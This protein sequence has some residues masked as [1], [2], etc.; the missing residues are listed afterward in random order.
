M[1]G[2]LAVALALAAG[3]ARAEPAPEPPRPA[4]APEATPWCAPELEALAD[5]LCSYAPEGESATRTLVVFL[6]GVIKPDTT[7]QYAQER[8]IVRGAKRHGFSVIMPRGRRGIGPKG[9]QDFFT[10]PTSVKAQRAVEA[11]LL[12]EWWSARAAL[13]ARSGRPF[14]RVYLVGFSNG[15]YYAA[16]LALR[17]KLAVDGYAL[18]AGGAGARYLVGP[19]KHT[20]RRPPI[21][22]GY[23]LKDPAHHDP[24]SLA[25]ALD[26][27][28]W[29][30][31]AR[32][33]RG[34]GHTMTD[35]GLAE[36]LDFFR[37]R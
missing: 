32:A 37:G 24:E 31:R 15:A 21:Y 9:M 13:E 19:A 28:G 35:A 14:E 10:W 23:G 1:R 33:R 18:F 25:R 8:A 29:R 27:L 16:S 36:A 3:A 22:V 34:V 5:G 12:A 4:T 6:H 2:A 11:E 20:R 17:G 7:W 30:H 26:E